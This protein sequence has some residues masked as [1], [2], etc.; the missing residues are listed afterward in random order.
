[1]AEGQLIVFLSQQL[2]SLF[3]TKMTHQ[4]IVMVTADWF[5][6]NDFGHKR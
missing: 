5:Y 4:K 3:D 2:A 1:M 6:P